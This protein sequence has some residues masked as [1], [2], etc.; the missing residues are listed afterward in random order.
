MTPKE[1]DT[2]FVLLLMANARVFRIPFTRQKLL[3]LIHET[4]E[5]PDCCHFHA[6]RRGI[7]RLAY[8]CR[9]HSEIL[10]IRRRKLVARQPRSHHARGKGHRACV[11][12]RSASLRT[13][14]VASDQSFTK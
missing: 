10:G 13:A 3:T 5:P 11:S 8:R 12:T 2:L 6:A 14:S 7:H 4:L 9:S 1:A